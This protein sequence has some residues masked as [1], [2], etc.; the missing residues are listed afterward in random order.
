MTDSYQL[1]PRKVQAWRLDWSNWEE[2][3]NKT[4]GKFHQ[5]LLIDRAA[6]RSTMPNQGRAYLELTLPDFSRAYCKMGDWIVEEVEG[7]FG[8]WS[9]A[10]FSETFE[11][12]PDVYVIV[13]NQPNQLAQGM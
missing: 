8:V 9:D 1:R 4:G 11:P 12:T 13:E 6:M 3:A 5:K 10:D 7:Q 2:L